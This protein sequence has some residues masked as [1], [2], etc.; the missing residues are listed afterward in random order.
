VRSLFA[1]LLFHVHAINASLRTSVL[2]R[3]H[4]STRTEGRIPA[5]VR[6][7]ACHNTQEAPPGVPEPETQ[8]SPISKGNCDLSYVSM[9][10]T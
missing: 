4:D 6:C 1:R 9:A 3:E 2:K 7:D 10:A 5:S 8:R